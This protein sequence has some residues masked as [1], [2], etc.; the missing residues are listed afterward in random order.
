[1]KL[2]P[3]LLFAASTAFALDGSSLHLLNQ[4]WPDVKTTRVSEIGRGV[5]VVFSPDLSVPGNCRFYQSL[6]FACFQSANW[7]EI[8][9]GIHSHNLLNPERRISTLVLETHGTN[10]NGLKLQ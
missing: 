4:A 1:M 8:L 9:D 5:G 10:G 3:I 7:E 2:I 6:G